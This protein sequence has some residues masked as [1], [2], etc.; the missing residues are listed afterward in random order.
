[1]EETTPLPV[2]FGVTADHPQAVQ[3]LLSA[4][5]KDI[6]EQLDRVAGKVEMGLRVVWDVPNIFEYF[7]NTHAE[8]RRARDL[9]FGGGREPAQEERMELGRMFE[10]ILEADRETCT[11][12]VERALA[13][14][15]T[16]I[17]R[18]RCQH[19]REVIHLACLIRREEQT[20]FE[21]AVFAAARGFDNNYSFDYNGPWAPHNFVELHLRPRG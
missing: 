6:L 14:Y 10:R 4:H 12:K 15:C 3:D 1:M 19:E 11:E 9:F 16:A 2:S 13:S 20:R 21:D 17:K 7:V 5:Q 8:L 18:N